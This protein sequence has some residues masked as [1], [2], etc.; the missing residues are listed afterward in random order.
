MNLNKMNNPYIELKIR[1]S[2][3][4]RPFLLTTTT[5]DAYN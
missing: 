5:N 2:Y 4:I 1:E 3:A